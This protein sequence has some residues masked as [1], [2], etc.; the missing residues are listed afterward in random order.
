MIIYLLFLFEGRCEVKDGV[1][2]GFL[3]E[4]GELLI[5]RLYDDFKDLN[6]K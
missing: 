1:G 6:L 3:V 4:R 2:I 5:L